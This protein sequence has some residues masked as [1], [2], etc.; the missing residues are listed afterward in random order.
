[1]KDNLKLIEPPCG[2]QVVKT[3]V[4]I[5]PRILK[6]NIHYFKNLHIETLMGTLN[7]WIILNT[8]WNPLSVKSFITAHTQICNNIGTVLE[9]K[10][11]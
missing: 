6:H 4:L 11:D 3:H 5:S 10:S 7:L 9:L 2:H 1:M 8:M